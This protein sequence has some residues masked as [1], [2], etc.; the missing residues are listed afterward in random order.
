MFHALVLEVGGHQGPSEAGVTAAM[1]AEHYGAGAASSVYPE[2]TPAR[3]AHHSQ[4]GHSST[5]VC[6]LLPMTTLNIP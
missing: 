6:V 2:G 5:R 1:Y 4:G 3:P